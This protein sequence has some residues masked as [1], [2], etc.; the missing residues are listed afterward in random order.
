M[1]KYTESQLMANKKILA[2]A[3]KMPEYACYTC[4]HACTHTHAHSVMSIV[5][6]AMSVL[7]I[8]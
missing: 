6:T 3:N 4:M 1:D 5:N 2:F 7:A 8:V